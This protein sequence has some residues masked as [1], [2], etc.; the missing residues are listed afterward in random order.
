MSTKNDKYSFIKQ[1]FTT[2][3]N[4]YY[5]LN[6][7]QNKKFP[8]LI[9]VQSYSKPNNDKYCG[10]AATNFTVSNDYEEK[11]KLRSWNKSSKAST[12]TTLNEDNN[13]L[14]KRWKN[15]NYLKITNKST[16][17]LHI[18]AYENSNEAIASDLFDD[19]NIE[20]L[21]KEKLGSIKTSKHCFIDR[22]MNPFDFPRQQNENQ[23]IEPEVAQFK[24]S[25]RLLASQPAT[26]SQQMPPGAAGTAGTKMAQTGLLKEKQSIGF[27]T[28]QDVFSFTFRTFDLKTQKI[29]SSA[30]YS[31]FKA[32]EFIDQIPKICS[33]FKLFIVDLFE[34]RFDAETFCGKTGYDFCKELKQIFQ[35]LQ[36]PSYFVATGNCLFSTLLLAANVDVKVDEKVLLILPYQLNEN[37]EGDKY[38]LAIGDFK[39]TQNGYQQVSYK[40]LPYLNFKDSPQNIFQQIC[41]SNI[42]KKVVAGNFG[43]RNPFR[44]VF[45]PKI[46]TVLTCCLGCHVD[47]FI[48]QTCKWF[49]DKSLTKYHIIQTSVKE[50]HVFA[51]YGAALQSSKP[52]IGKNILDILKINACDPLPITK[53][54]IF[55]RSI[56]E[57]QGS[58]LIIGCFSRLPHP[59][60]NLHKNIELS[61]CGE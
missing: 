39:F 46:L 10:I 17:S 13:D 38:G 53:T 20:G 15:K 58:S 1:N 29:V 22:L 12:F 52:S 23:R 14:K 36:I 50:I 8:I 37:P 6:L 25:Q 51:N 31:T 19:E 45:K 48:A 5:D 42:P 21:K 33:T 18:A 28:R 3:E 32:E 40:R 4:Q 30:I 56:P 26:T 27:L 44:K 34:I 11:G 49:F 41:G 16:L 7:N 55:P 35:E 43:P 57:M 2:S 24:A 54:A 59:T 61:G 9:P 47:K 60:K